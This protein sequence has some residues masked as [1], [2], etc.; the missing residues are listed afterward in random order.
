MTIVKRTL[1]IFNAIIVTLLV[2][3]FASTLYL[4][5]SSRA[6]NG[7]PTVAGQT[8]YEVLSGSME[9][10]F[11]TGSVIFDNPH[12][13][14]NALHKGDIIT[15]HLPKNSG[16]NGMTGVLVTHR[17]ERV[18]HE[19][20]QIE[21][22]TKG[23]ANPSVDP[24]VVKPQNI[25]AQYDNFT[26]PYVGYYL[27]FIHGRWGDGLL[28]IIPGA[29]LVISSMI[30]LFREVLSLQRRASKPAAVTSEGENLPQ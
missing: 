3:V 27:N 11:D 16:F 18:F 17:I 22:Q 6:N 14:I 29:F 9:P 20:G 30:T 25:V 10:T 23:D 15:F 4:T 28:L 26:I 1:N 21:F 19:N 5:I 12:V 7:N 24:W 8:M 2:I 13:N